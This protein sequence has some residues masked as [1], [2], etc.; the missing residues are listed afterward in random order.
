MPQYLKKRFGGTRISLYLSVISLF[1]YIFTKISVSPAVQAFRK[2]AFGVCVCASFPRCLCP[3][4]YVFRGGVYPAGIRMEYL[5]RCHHSSVDN[6]LIYCYRYV[7]T[8]FNGG[9]FN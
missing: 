7:N 4:G 8:C 6:S 3:G 2:I 5:R 1:L 9:I